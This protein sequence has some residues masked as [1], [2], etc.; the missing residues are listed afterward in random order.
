MGW[1]VDLNRCLKQAFETGVW[2]LGRPGGNSEKVVG[3][4]EC[5]YNVP[6]VGETV[7]EQVHRPRDDAVEILSTKS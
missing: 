7:H 1:I 3:C 6:V 2:P 5:R 4:R